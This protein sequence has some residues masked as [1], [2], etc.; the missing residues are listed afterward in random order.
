MRLQETGRRGFSWRSV[1]E[2]VPVIQIA[3]DTERARCSEG[4]GRAFRRLLQPGRACRVD[5]KPL[6]A[7]RKRGQHQ[8]DRS[9]PGERFRPMSSV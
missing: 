4:M 3:H 5:R 9:L 1:S 6:K 2:D 8:P 7:Q